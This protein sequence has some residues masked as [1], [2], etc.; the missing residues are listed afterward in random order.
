VARLPAV[1]SEYEREAAGRMQQVEQRAD[2][3]RL[4]GA[5]GAEEA[6]D[7]YAL[8]RDRDVVDPRVF[9]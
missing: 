9:P 6:V 7:L 2:R 3:C 1:E 5:I 8:D 4:A